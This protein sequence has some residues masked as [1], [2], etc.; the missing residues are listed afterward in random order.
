MRLMGLETIYS[1]CLTAHPAEE[2]QR[3]NVSSTQ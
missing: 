3:H 1:I 2:T